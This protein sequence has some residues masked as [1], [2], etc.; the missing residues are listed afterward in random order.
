MTK[1]SANTPITGRSSDAPP[2]VLRILFRLAKI[3][4]LT[5]KSPSIGMLVRQDLT[6]NSATAIKKRSSTLQ[7][8]ALSLR[9]ERMGAQKA[10]QWT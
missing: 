8:H 3:G 9:K 7:W 2:Y 6:A 1:A 4:S 10:W 5:K